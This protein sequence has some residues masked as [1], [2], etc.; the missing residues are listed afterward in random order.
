MRPFCNSSSR[1]DTHYRLTRK[2]AEALLSVRGATYHAH[3]PPRVA[4]SR[5]FESHHLAVK[6]MNEVLIRLTRN[7]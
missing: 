4:S 2:D 3:V 1:M 5:S 6:A 7:G